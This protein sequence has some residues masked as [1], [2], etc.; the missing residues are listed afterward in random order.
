[1]GI[2]EG[3]PGQQHRPVHNDISFG[4]DRKGANALLGKLTIAARMK[5]ARDGHL[6][7]PS[8]SLAA[9]GASHL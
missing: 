9:S 2:V 6:S 3:Y 7:R 8:S 1:M 5:E 4:I